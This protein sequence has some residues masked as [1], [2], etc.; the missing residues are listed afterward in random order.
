MFHKARASGVH[1]H[2]EFSTDELLTF[3]RAALTRNITSD[4]L[5][6]R[7]VVGDFTLDEKY[8]LTRELGVRLLDRILKES[9]RQLREVKRSDAKAKRRPRRHR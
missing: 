8:E 5:I 4:E 2:I 6:R 7:I 3:A 9:T 1:I